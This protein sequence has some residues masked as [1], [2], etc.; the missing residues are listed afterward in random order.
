MPLAL[1]RKSQR[2]AH[3]MHATALR[4]GSVHLR[5][6]RLEPEMRVADHQ[7]HAAKSAAGQVAQELQSERLGFARA[8]GDADDFPYATRLTATAN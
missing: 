7:L 5:D 3:E 4:R 8:N 1:A 6:R 2:V